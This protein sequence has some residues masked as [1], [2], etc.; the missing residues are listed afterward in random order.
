MIPHFLN[1]IL[2]EKSLEEIYNVGDYPPLDYTYDNYDGEEKEINF[3]GAVSSSS[4]NIIEENFK[5]TTLEQNTS[6]TT[7]SEHSF[8]VATAVE[9]DTSEITAAFDETVTPEKDTSVSTF[10]WNETASESTS[11]TVSTSVIEA[12]STEIG[13]EEQSI[14]TTLEITESPIITSRFTERSTEETMEEEINTDESSTLPEG[15]IPLT[16]KDYVVKCFEQVCVTTTQ[17]TSKNRV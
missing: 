2:D 13:T 15:V 11:E 1:P 3:G 4:T 14:I 12:S 10:D 5:M 6:E 16:E 8:E 7:M 9:N 17:D